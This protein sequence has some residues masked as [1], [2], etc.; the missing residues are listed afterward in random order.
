MNYRTKIDFLREAIS[1]DIVDIVLKHNDG[2]LT[3]PN[4]L[5]KDAP[6]IEDGINDVDK[7]R[8]NK[9]IAV[10]S[11]SFEAFASNDY[12]EDVTMQ[13]SII[14]T[15]L[16]LALYEWLVENEVYIK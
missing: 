9:I 8:L 11:N 12:D 6:I 2:I 16:L 7:M 3:I 5:L 14:S 10:S 1:L 4:E 15:D 13:S